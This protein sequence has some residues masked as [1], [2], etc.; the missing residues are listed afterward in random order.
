MTWIHYLTV[1]LSL[2]LPVLLVLAWIAKG[3]ANSMRDIGTTGSAPQF[4]D[5]NK[6]ASA[7]TWLWIGLT[8]FAV[9]SLLEVAARYSM[10]YFGGF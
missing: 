7:T 1:I 3:A 6:H 5:W 4:I 10:S 2:F 8:L 9:V